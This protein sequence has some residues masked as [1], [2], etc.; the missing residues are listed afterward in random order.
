MLVEV[1]EQ[2]KLAMS[3]QDVQTY[4][5]LQRV[6]RALEH[7][8]TMEY[9]KS[10]PYLLNFMDDYQLKRDFEETAL[11]RSRNGGI[12]ESLRAGNGLLLPWE[13]I[14]RYEPV[15]P[16][17]ARL[18]ALMV[19]MLDGGAWRLLWVPPSLPY[20]RPAGALAGG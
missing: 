19:D 18:R 10:A 15:D 11:D 16:A 3:P 5:T 4:P 9:W 7:T 17:N 2:A 12:L 8:D 6:A 14:T 13:D 1:P 20:Y